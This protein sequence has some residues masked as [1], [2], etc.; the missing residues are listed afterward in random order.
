MEEDD[1][2]FPPLSLSLP[3]NSSSDNR[4]T[5]IFILANIEFK[6]CNYQFD[7]TTCHCLMWFY[8][9]FAYFCYV[10]RESHSNKSNCCRCLTLLKLHIILLRRLL[11]IENHGEDI[12]FNFYDRLQRNLLQNLSPNGLLIPKIFSLFLYI[13]VY[14]YRKKFTLS[15]NENQSIEDWTRHR[16]QSV[17]SNR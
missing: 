3:F 12:L 2:Q 6:L 11:D 9:T 4:L 17:E 5:G 14:Q 15:S 16:F 1:I 13:Y 10:F 7:F 8:F